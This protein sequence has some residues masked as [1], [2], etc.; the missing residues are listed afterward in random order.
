MEEAHT[1][2]HTHTH[3]H[4]KNEK[5]RKKKKRIHRCIEG[6]LRVKER[7]FPSK[8]EDVEDDE[9]ADENEEEEEGGHFLLVPRVPSEDRWNDCDRHLFLLS[10]S[11][12]RFL[13]FLLNEMK[14][15]RK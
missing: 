10:L 11:L 5:K 15:K 3:T 8:K 13:S 9:D 14:K 6:R 4:K 2:T 7:P 12:S 1:H